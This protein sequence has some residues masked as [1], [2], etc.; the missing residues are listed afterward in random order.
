MSESSRDSFMFF[1]LTL[2]QRI[3]CKGMC[4]D[5]AGSSHCKQTYHGAYGLKSAV[6]GCG[7]WLDQSE[8][9]AMAEVSLPVLGRPVN[10]K[11]KR[12]LLAGKLS[13]RQSY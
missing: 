3:Y 6:Q 10:A 13:K 4:G 1:G 2:Q 12:S 5:I 11:E 9:R 8:Y 7:R